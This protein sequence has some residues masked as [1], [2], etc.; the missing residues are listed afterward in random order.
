MWYTS[1][2]D[3]GW[4]EYPLLSCDGITCP[5][6]EKIV[7]G[8]GCGKVKWHD[9]VDRWASLLWSWKKILALDDKVSNCLFKYLKFKFRLRC[10]IKDIFFSRMRNLEY[11]WLI[12]QIYWIESVIFRISQF[13]IIKYLI[14]KKRKFNV[15]KFDIMIKYLEE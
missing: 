12:K 3:G 2:E 1:L 9:E 14:I 15:S 8:G 13:V 6:L 5:T 7:K 11:W 10:I 4:Q